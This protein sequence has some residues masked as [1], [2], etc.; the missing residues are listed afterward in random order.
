M[1]RRPPQS[2]LVWLR[3]LFTLCLAAAST[4][5]LSAPSPKAEAL[6]KQHK[7]MQAKLAN[8]PFGRPILV[9]SAELADGLRGDVYAV[10]NHSLDDV[11]EALSV[12]ANWCDMMLLHIDNRQC[13]LSKSDGGQHKLSLSVVRNYDQPVEDAFVL[14]LEFRVNAATPDYFAVELRSAEGPLGTSN[15]FVLLEAVSIQ[16]A[17]TFLHFSYSY[18]HNMVARMATQAYLATFGS[19]KVGF[20]VVGKDAKGAPDYIRGL[21]GLVERNAVRYFLTADAYLDAMHAP[22][23]RQADQR[24]ERWYAS[25]ERYPRQLHEV[26]FETY[27]ELKRA[28][29]LRNAS[30]H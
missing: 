28:D 12:P 24:F 11:V 9:D 7:A 3:W 14:P 27:R 30:S 16:P 23:L 18:D 2:R 5:V 15:H 22:P 1:T 13:V 10:I 6:L 19:H 25:A 8:N 20:T 17:Q 4:A 26:D 29:R 21:R